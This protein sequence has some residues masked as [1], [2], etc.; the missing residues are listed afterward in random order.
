MQTI[1]SNP[2]HHHASKAC[3]ELYQ[4]DTG[5]LHAPTLP[6][7]LVPKRNEQENDLTLLPKVAHIAPP[8]CAS[9]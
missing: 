5:H 4:P 2:R 3:L 8:S 7:D 6:Y 9:F 1:A